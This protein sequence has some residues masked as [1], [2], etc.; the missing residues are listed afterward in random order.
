MYTQQHGEHIPQIGMYFFRKLMRVI[1][2]L[3]I[4]IYFQFF[5]MIM[6][7]VDFN[8]F[9]SHSFFLSVNNT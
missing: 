1:L 8:M 2:K 7:D 3:F 5:L 9:I 6:T 4:N